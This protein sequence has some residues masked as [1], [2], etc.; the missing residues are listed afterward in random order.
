MKQKETDIEILKVSWEK[1]HVPLRQGI[2]IDDAKELNT[3]LKALAT[4]LKKI[5][6]WA[7][8]EFLLEQWMGRIGP[9]AST[10]SLA[11]KGRIASKPRPF[12][13]KLIK[14]YGKGRYRIY[15]EPLKALFDEFH[16]DVVDQSRLAPFFLRKGFVPS[17]YSA[18]SMSVS[19]LA[20]LLEEK[21]SMV[22]E[23][24]RDTR[25]ITIQLKAKTRVA[26][27]AG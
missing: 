27:S 2:T 23:I 9:D 18:S 11:T 12:F 3:D 13:G 21:P 22:K 10:S 1:G 19:Y 5:N 7:D 17:E 8:V 15:E 14:D 24:L 26:G 16:G 6:R 20:Y 4:L 25:P